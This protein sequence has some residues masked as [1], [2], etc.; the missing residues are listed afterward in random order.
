MHIYKTNCTYSPSLITRASCF[1]AAS[2]YRMSSFLKKNG[3]CSSCC[4]Y[5][6][7]VVLLK[8]IC[9]DILWSRG[10]LGLSNFISSTNWCLKG[11]VSCE[12]TY[13]F[14]QPKDES[15]K[16]DDGWSYINHDDVIKWKHFRRYWQFVR[17]IHLFTCKIPFTKARCFL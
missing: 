5:Q 10:R 11:E 1:N 7:R 3:S 9:V 16:T 6:Y 14:E 8:H 13:I 2:T 15:M 12:K 17:G 4:E